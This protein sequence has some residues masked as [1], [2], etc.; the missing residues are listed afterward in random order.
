MSR[1]LAPGVRIREGDCEALGLSS[2]R[3]LFSLFFSLLRLTF[4]SAN[5]CGDDVLTRR[6]RKANPADVLPYTYL[7]TGGR[8]KY[9]YTTMRNVTAEQAGHFL[10]PERIEALRDTV[11]KG[12]SYAL[13]PVGL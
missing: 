10:Q 3:S 5:L 13:M 12:D 9:D 2:V 11:D 8:R 4:L 6:R 1:L 7:T